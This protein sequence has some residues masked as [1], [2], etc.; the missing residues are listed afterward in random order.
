VD[1][2]FCL[3]IRLLVYKIVEKENITLLLIFLQQLSTFFQQ[4]R[5]DY[6]FI[7]KAYEVKRL[8]LL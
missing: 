7:K 8:I 5:L 1:K 2:N 6:L 3:F 4:L